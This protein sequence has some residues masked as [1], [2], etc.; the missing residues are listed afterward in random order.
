M[1]LESLALIAIIFTY[2]SKKCA[3]SSPT[4]ETKTKLITFYFNFTASHGGV[5]LLPINCLVEQTE[6]DALINTMPNFGARFSWRCVANGQNEPYEINVSLYDALQG[7]TQGPDRWQLDRFICAHAIM[8]S[9][10]G[11]PGIYIHSMLGTQNDH[12]RLELTN[13]NRNINR[14]K[15]SLEELETQ[16]SSPNNHHRLVLD[17]ITG[18]LKLRTKQPAFHPNAVQYTL[19]LG[20]NVFGFWRQSTDRLQSIFCIHNL[21]NQE[22]NIPISSINLIS[23]QEWS[24]LVTG[25]S[26]D[27]QQDSL[28]LRPYQFAWLSNRR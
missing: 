24:D 1:V 23:T 13:H 27:E 20:D 16:L 7:T 11:I 3:H 22:V 14:H 10:E 9:L 18:L 17:A 6:F 2:S 15:W 19:H 5:G 4:L 8:F 26:L 21:S 25:E 12:E 28:H